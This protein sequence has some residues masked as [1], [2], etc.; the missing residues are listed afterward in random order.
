MDASGIS[1]GP[2]PASIRGTR[3]SCSPWPTRCSDPILRE[4]LFNPEPQL[5]HLRSQLA[6]AKHGLKREAYQGHVRID[7]DFANGYTF[8]SLT[9]VHQDKSQNIIDL[10]YRDGR[11]GTE[12][13]LW[14]LLLPK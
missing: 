10:N 5:G 8:T 3:I 12:Y 14:R 2:C 1:A 11:R 6:Y 13:G 4:T 9:A 7:W